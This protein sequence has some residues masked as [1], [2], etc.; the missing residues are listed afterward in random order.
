M[1]D[2]EHSASIVSEYDRSRGRSW[3]DHKSISVWQR[4]AEPIWLDIAQSDVLSHHMARAEAD[5]RHISP[6]QKT[7]VRRCLQLWTNSGDVVFS[8]FAGI[9]TAGYVAI[10]MERK[11]IGVELKE[12]YYKQAIDNLRVAEKAVG[13]Q[14][15]FGKEAA[16]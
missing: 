9:G 8:P 12:S 11:F 7:V 3:D 2:A 1:T 10:E 15:L 13:A 4:Y 14:T 6:L 5:E 16:E